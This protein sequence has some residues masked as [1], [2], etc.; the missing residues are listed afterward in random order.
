MNNRIFVTAD[1]HFGHKKIIEFEPCRSMFKTIEEHDEELVR[2]WNDT[3]N[4]HDTVWHLGDAVFGADNL[5]ILGR[6][7]G[8]KRLVMGNHDHYPSTEYLKYFTHLFGVV[9]LRGHILSHVPVHT[10]QMG[11][12]QGN[13]HGHMHSGTMNDPRYACVSVEH[14]NLAPILLDT[15]LNNMEKQSCKPAT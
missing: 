14:G 2:R 12:F 3:V 7:N 1:T 9:Q 6:L 13:I 11:R 10:Q 5:P 15:V 8:I 4:K